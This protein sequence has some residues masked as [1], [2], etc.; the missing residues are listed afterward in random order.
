LYL[1]ALRL[2]WA[3]GTTLQLEHAR[4]LPLEILDIWEVAVWEIAFGKSLTSFYVTLH[5]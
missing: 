2:G 5:L 3:R 1:T 4:K